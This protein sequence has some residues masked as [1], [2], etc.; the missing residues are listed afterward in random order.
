MPAIPP[1]LFAAM[2]S[3]RCP[4]C[5]MKDVDVTLLTLDP[6]SGEHY[7]KQCAYAGS[8]KEIEHLF[9]I[10]T[11]HRYKQAGQPHPFAERRRETD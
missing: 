10:F 9:E 4:M 3:Y 1:P 7:C 5:F 11:R 2:K 8:A 6:T